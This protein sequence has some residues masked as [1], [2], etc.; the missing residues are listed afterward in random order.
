[1]VD[2]ST[3][4]ATPNN[5]YLA[6]EQSCK[7]LDAATGEVRDEITVPADL[8]GGTFW[9]W[10]AMFDGVLYA[11]V[12]EQEPLDE[13]AR[14]RRTAGGWPWNEISKGFNAND[15]KNFDPRSW[16]R[17]ETFDQRDHAWGFSK[18]LLAIDPGTKQV[19]WSHREELPIDSRTLCMKS[20]RVYLS[21]FSR[22]IACL[23][24]KSGEEICAKTAEQDPELFKAIGPYCPY[25]VASTGWRSTIYARCSDE[26]LI[27]AGPQVF[28]VTA[29]STADGHHLWTYRAAKSSRSDPR[30]RRVSDRSGRTQ[31]GHSQARPAHRQ[32]PGKL[33]HFENILHSRDGL[34]T[35]SSSGEVAMAR[36][37]SNRPAIARNGCR[38]CVPRALS[39]R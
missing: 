37:A 19:L 21:H 31:H 28:D 13:I 33:Q 35:A 6:D 16:R 9:K 14:W 22:Y 27:F 2:R 24:A 30:R 36:F 11:L 8:V 23:N 3:M 39:G 25:E 12:G 18:A 29:I 15:P 5:L 4:I 10:M 34:R 32:D 20:G 26:V 7:V 1:M 17:K 38:R